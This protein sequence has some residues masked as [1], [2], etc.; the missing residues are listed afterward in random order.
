MFSPKYIKY[1]IVIF[2]ALALLMPFISINV[3]CSDRDFEKEEK[4]GQKMANRIEKRYE[5]VEDKENL[6]RIKEIGS[7]LIKI[8]DL[9]EINYQIKIIDREGPN[10]FAFPGGFIYLT[11]DLFDHIHS[12]DELAAII[13]HE[14]GHIIHQHS[15]KQMQDNRKLK[16]VELFAILLTGD[17]AIGLL[18]EL[19]TIT[20]LNSY[21]REYEEEADFTA[22]ELLNKS[23]K[24]S[25]VGLLTYFER[26]SSERFLKPTVNMGIFQTHPEMK[27]RIR[28]VQQ[29]LDE[30]NI[31]IDRRKTT[32]YLTVSGVVDIFKDISI[33]RILIDEEEILQ[34][35]GKES[36]AYQ[37]I[38]QILK[39]L[40]ESLKIS[41]EPYQ[42]TLYTD[43][44]SNTCTMR[45]GNNVII[46]LADEE[47]EYQ[48]FTSTE[49]LEKTKKNISNILWKLKLKLPALLLN[50]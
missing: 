48:G 45:I 18:S 34:F 43:T 16:L 35:S 4:I 26:I 29:F 22:L 1:K 36:T 30:N 20:I 32:N 5:I 41:L 27:E 21:S 40:D 9:K 38:D 15:I 50:S 13:A 10:A 39:R 17:P 33:A 37:K 14:M 6:A 7:N 49:A 2:L 46:S 19:T 25:P 8:S 23:S 28:R 42:I 3:Y 11:A 31:H 24:Y 44:K 47:V 12:D